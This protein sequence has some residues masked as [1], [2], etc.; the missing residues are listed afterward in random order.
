MTGVEPAIIG[1]IAKLAAPILPIAIKGIQ[2][3]LK[4]RQVRDSDVETLKSQ[5]S[6][7]QGI[8]RDTRKTIRSSQEAK[9]RP[10]GFN[11]VLDTSDAWRTTSKT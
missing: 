6:Y 9:T 1:A 5:L 8:I 3:A 7:I 11:P 2:G 4:K 10:T